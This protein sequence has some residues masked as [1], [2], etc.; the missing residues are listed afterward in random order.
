MHV[1]MYIIIIFPYLFHD[2]PDL[3]YVRVPHKSYVAGQLWL[4]GTLIKKLIH[5]YHFHGKYMELKMQN[6]RNTVF[7]RKQ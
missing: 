4:G 6:D 7:T 2:M 5:A 3:Y 1:C